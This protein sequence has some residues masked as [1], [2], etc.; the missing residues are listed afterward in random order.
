[1]WRARVTDDGA[2]EWLALSLGTLSRE[3]VVA[4][5]TDTLYGLG[6]DPRS[7]AAVARLYR[8]KG[9][10]VDQAIPLIASD[11]AQLEACGAVLSPLGARLAEALWP[12]PLT[13]VIDA[14]PGLDAALLAGGD[15]VA[16]RVP[17]HD[18]ARALA[19]GLGHPI[20]STSANRSG[21]PATP[22]PD[23]VAAAIGPDL[24]GLV[25]AGR[26]PGGPA[27]TIVDARGRAPRLLR[28]GVVPWERVL[29]F[30]R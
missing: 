3:G 2:G 21:E 7:A 8:I 10:A 5:P 1:M 26:A 30:E 28:A 17:A 19:R 12:G 11:R 25:D 18:V 16:V 9:R 24:D 27:S 15:G 6:A 14:W 13:L 20:T 22:D 4:Y 23:A 29:E